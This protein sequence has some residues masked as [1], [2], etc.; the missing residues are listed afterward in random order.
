M[1]QP[2]AKFLSKIGT[3]LFLTVVVAPAFYNYDL[4][5]DGGLRKLLQTQFWSYLYC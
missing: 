1:L 2:V 4:Y 3:I 5:V